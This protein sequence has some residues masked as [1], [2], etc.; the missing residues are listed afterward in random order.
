[1]WIFYNSN[2]EALV[3]HAESE[4]TQTEIEGETA[5][6]KFV[7]PDLVRNSPGVAKAWVSITGAGARNTPYYNVSSITDTDTGDRTIVFDTDFSGVIYVGADGHFDAAATFYKSSYSSIAA[8]SVRLR[9]FN[10][11]GA[12]VDIETTNA[13]YGDQ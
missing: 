7:P 3:Q 8:G 12:T 1:M 11:A 13:F 5:T 6:A 10:A 4:A 2:G 9:I